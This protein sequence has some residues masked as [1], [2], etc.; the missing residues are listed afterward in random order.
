MRTFSLSVALC[1]F[2]TTATTARPGYLAAGYPAPLRFGETGRYA[3]GRATA[4]PQK[5]IGGGRIRA[6]GTLTTAPGWI[7]FESVSDDLFPS[8][9]WIGFYTYSS[10]P[11]RHRM[12][13][14][15]DFGNGNVSGDG[16]DDIGPFVIRGRYDATSKECHWTKT[17]VGKHDVF[18]KG[19]REGKGIWGTW[20]V[21]DATG[22]FK[23]WPLANGESDDTMEAEPKEELVEA[24][25]A[26]AGA[27][28]S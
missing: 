19:F 14:A 26:L 25:G 22:G 28:E 6:G 21:G 16:D 18:Y 7:K 5:R 2:V 4:T 27:R 1:I 8:G 10:D 12:D 3:W 20:E 23:I 17:Y 13:L 11:A 24:V 9:P 15:L